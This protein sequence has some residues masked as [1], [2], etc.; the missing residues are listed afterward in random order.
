MPYWAVISGYMYHDQ[1]FSLFLHFWCGLILRIISFDYLLLKLFI[2][3]ATCFIVDFS[4]DIYRSMIW[5]NHKWSKSW[6]LEQKSYIVEV[7]HLI[8]SIKS[9]VGLYWYENTVG[10]ILYISDSRNRSGT[11]MGCCEV[12]IVTRIRDIIVLGIGGR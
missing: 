4:Q 12:I 5:G 6:C 11:S 9:V 8:M 7:A 10:I 1:E 3:T 2:K